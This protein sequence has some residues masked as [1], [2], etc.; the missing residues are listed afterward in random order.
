MV[1]NFVPNCDF[2]GREIPLGFEMRRNVSPSGVEILM[3]ALENSDP[4][5][6]FIQNADGTL[7]FD[8]CPDCYTRV[9]FQHSSLVN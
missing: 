9:A 2:C 6:E 3:I 1:K 5:L 8:T 4:D 7:S